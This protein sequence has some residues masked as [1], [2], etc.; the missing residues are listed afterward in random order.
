M[1]MS[2][3]HKLKRVFVALLGRGRWWVTV[4]LFVVAMAACL[5]VVQ[6]HRA[7]YTWGLFRHASVYD[8]IEVLGNRR[9]VQVVTEALRRLKASSPNEYALIQPYVRRIEQSRRSGAAAWNDPPTIFLSKRSAFY[10]TT[11]CA[12]AIIHDGYHVRLYHDHIR[13][14]GT[15]VPD[16]AW[17]GR[18]IE[19]RCIQVQITAATNVGAPQAEL[20]YLAGLDGTH[21]DLDNDSRD[22]WYD[23]WARDW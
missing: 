5:M 16:S 1:M 15:P 12:G 2:I 3:G 13:Q 23:Y 6:G 8:E 20:D 7:G 22:T 17:R 10:S 18:A 9:F 19:L 4:V 14:H 21:F 11:W